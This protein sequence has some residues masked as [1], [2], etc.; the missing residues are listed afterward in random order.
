MAPTIPSF[1]FCCQRWGLDAHERRWP[2]RRPRRP[3][4]PLPPLQ[5]RSL[6]G[7]CPTETSGRPAPPTG[8]HRCGSCFRSPVLRIVIFFLRLWQAGQSVTLS[9]LF[10][11]SSYYVGLGPSWSPLNNDLAHGPWFC[12]AP[13]RTRIFAAV[14]L[15]AS[16]AYVLARGAC[17]E[18]VPRWFL[19]IFYNFPRVGFFPGRPAWMITRR[20]TGGWSLQLGLRRVRCLLQPFPSPFSLPLLRT[21]SRLPSPPSSRRAHL[22]SPGA[23]RATSTSTLL[24]EPAPPPS[25]FACF[26]CLSELYRSLFSRYALSG[27]FFFRVLDVDNLRQCVSPRWGLRK[28][29]PVILPGTCLISVLRL[30]PRCVERRFFKRSFPR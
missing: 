4:E 25:F 20:T 28:F 8:K 5:C 29:S 30:R 21:T 11:P 15:G 13:F 6:S 16:F 26:L 22:L 2:S 10:L 23:R 19:C 9:F 18:H 12:L 17:Y 27:P 7:S 14:T 1:S 3:P 24:N